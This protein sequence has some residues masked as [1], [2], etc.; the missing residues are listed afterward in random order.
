MTSAA[1]NKS[2]AIL[3]LLEKAN[4]A[5]FLL[6]IAV[7]MSFLY[8]ANGFGL[9]HIFNAELSSSHL[10]A[11]PSNKAHTTNIK[12]DKKWLFVTIN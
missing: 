8:A 10:P 4:L 12:Y 2:M 7:V 11:L 1:A 3:C 6:P 9:P 5:H